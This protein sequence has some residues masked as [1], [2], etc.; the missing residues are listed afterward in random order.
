MVGAT[1]LVQVHSGKVPEDRVI[2]RALA[3]EMRNW[4]NLEVRLRCVRNA[5]D[6]TWKERRERNRGREVVIGDAK[7]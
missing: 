7:L 4:P 1:A 6:I 3:E 2:L 5:S